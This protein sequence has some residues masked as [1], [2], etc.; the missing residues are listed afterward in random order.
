[1]IYAYLHRL[2]EFFQEVKDLMP[3]VGLSS[4]M[5]RVH[6]SKDLNPGL[7]YLNKFNVFKFH[8][9]KNHPCL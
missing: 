8:E 2:T 7:T 5:K 3:I 6:F 4:S 1:M 9:I